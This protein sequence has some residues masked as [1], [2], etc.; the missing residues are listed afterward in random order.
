MGLHVDPSSANVPDRLPNQLFN[1]KSC[2]S[3]G[4][5]VETSIPEVRSNGL[6]KND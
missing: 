6:G 5:R 2:L 1:P 3:S 4:R